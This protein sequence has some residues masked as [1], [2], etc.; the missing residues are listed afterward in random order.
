MGLDIWPTCQC[1]SL[2]HYFLCKS[3]A[4]SQNLI[5]NS[6]PET[7]EAR[8]HI[9]QMSF[10]HNFFVLGIQNVRVANNWIQA[11]QKTQSLFSIEKD[12]F[13]LP[14]G[15]SCYCSVDWLLVC[16]K[17]LRTNHQVFNKSIKLQISYFSIP[18]PFNI[19]KK[20]NVLPLRQNQFLQ[21]PLPPFT[22]H[23]SFLRHAL[24]GVMPEQA[25]IRCLNLQTLYLYNCIYRNPES[26]DFGIRNEQ[27]EKNHDLLQFVHLF[28]KLFESKVSFIIDLSK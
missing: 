9:G 24:S 14:Q 1:L 25:V 12:N 8:L 15:S 7:S 22:L 18:L 13:F 19:T 23:F 5:H 16:L 26:A 4:F 27:R 6:T 11:V 28:L 3:S 21:I 17:Q 2:G 10:G 20:E